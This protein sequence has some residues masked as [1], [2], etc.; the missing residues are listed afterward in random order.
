VTKF[1][2]KFAAGLNIFGGKRSFY[3]VNYVGENCSSLAHTS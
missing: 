1:D 3:S 2:N